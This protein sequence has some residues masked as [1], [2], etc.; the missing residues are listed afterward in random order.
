MVDRVCTGCEVSG[1][2]VNVIAEPWRGSI[3]VLD[4]KLHGRV[5]VRVRVGVRVRVRCSTRSCTVGSGL[6]LGLGLGCGLGA[7]PEAAR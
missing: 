4:S 5:R 3:V 6:G 2:G 1:E 7:R